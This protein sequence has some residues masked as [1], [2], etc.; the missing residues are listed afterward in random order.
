MT[1]KNIEKRIAQAKLADPT[2]A[3]Q[4]RTKK[5]GKH[6]I[7]IY[8]YDDPD[9]H[10]IWTGPAIHGRNGMGKKPWEKDCKNFMD[11]L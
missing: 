4:G 7:R 2:M 3:F 5:T 9:G 10:H 11:I 8:F 1:K 6:R